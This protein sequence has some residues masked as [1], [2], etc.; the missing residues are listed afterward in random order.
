M[1]YYNRGFL[2]P[3]HGMAAFI[4]SIEYDPPRDKDDCHNTSIYAEFEISDCSR[5]IALD[6][7]IYD[8]DDWLKA[9]HK[10]NTLQGELATFREELIRAR[11]LHKEGAALA[12]ANY[13]RVKDE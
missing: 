9:I 8:D 10:L 12:K 6:F 1:K 2:N 5:K 11:E 13:E 4:A 7:S 3:K